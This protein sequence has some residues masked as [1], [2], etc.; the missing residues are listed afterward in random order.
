MRNPGEKAKGVKGGR[1]MK[2]ATLIAM[3]IGLSGCLTVAQQIDN[4]CAGYGFKPGTDGF[5]SCRMQKEHE[6]WY[7]R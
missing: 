1:T 7:G 5:A 3:A 6:F 2:W 4:Q